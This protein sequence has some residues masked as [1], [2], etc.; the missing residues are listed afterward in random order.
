VST[1]LETTETETTPPVTPGVTPHASRVTPAAL[2][3][4]RLGQGTPADESNAAAEIDRLREKMRLME[5]A[6]REEW[7]TLREFLNTH[8]ARAE[9]VKAENSLSDLDPADFVQCLQAGAA[10]G[11]A[12]GM[13]MAFRAVLDHNDAMTRTGGAEPGATQ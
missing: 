4:L 7:A 12:G 13:E 10:Y 9:R 3:R 2:S 5:A 1:T 8:I 6:N 11:S